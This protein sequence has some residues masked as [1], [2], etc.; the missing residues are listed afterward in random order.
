[1]NHSVI[2]TIRRALAFLLA[3][4]VLS[5]SAGCSR[6]KGTVPAAAV[7]TLTGAITERTA[8]VR[9]HSL[10]AVDPRAMQTPMAS[11]GL[12]QLFLDKKSYGIAL[13]EKTR[14]KYWYAMPS[15]TGGAF[16]DGACVVTLD[17]LYGN[18]VY[19]L[20]SQDD[21]VQYGNVAVLQEDASKDSEFTVC[22]VLTADE[23]TAG[24]ITKEEIVGGKIRSDR[25]GRT[26]IAYAVHVTYTLRDGNLYVGAQWQ[27]LSEN[28]DATVRS[29]S[30]LP[31]FGAQG[32]AEKG[33][34]FLIPDGCGAAIHTDIQDPAFENIDLKVYGADPAVGEDEGTLPALC[35]AFASKQGDN[36]FA[37]IIEAGDAVATIQARRGAGNGAL[38]R[39][40]ASFCITD[41]HA[42]QKNGKDVTFVSKTSYTGD[43]RLCVRLLGGGNAGLDGITAAC[44]EQFMRMGYLSTDTIRNEEYLP[45]RLEIRGAGDSSGFFRTANVMTSFEQAQ[46]MLT[47]MKAKGINNVDIRYMGALSGGADQQRI[48]A[49]RF[50]RGLGG[51]NGLNTLSEFCTAQGHSL[52]LDASLFTYS[53]DNRFGAPAALSIESTD[54]HTQQ[55]LSDGTKQRALLRLNL[56]EEMVI[57]LLT[58]AKKV[59]AD[60]F[61]LADAGNV[62]YS[63]Y[64]EPYTNRAAAADILRTQLPA[65]S[66]DRLLMIDGGNFYAIRYADLLNRLPQSPAKEER[67]KLYTA[68]PFIQM[69]LHGTL[70]YA[71][72]PVNLAED[73]VA[74]QLRS[75]E[76]GACPC[77][78]WCFEKGDETLYYENQLNDA[79]A[80]YQKAN[81]ALADLRDAR[82]MDN[83]ETGTSGIH[84][85]QYDNGAIVYV[86][87]NDTAS[88]VG[89]IRVSAHAFQRIG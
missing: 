52:F 13:Y 8:Q 80:F 47:R 54:A 45:F 59:Q 81:A 44:R 70:D 23:T 75:V 51:R 78:A 89:N 72:I 3:L 65:M 64:T 32:K 9:D 12:V 56:L 17:V 39:V 88:T 1:M 69:I 42:G 31:W 5:A 40:G 15:V 34:Y 19:R 20:N 30:L 46:D 49:I 66:T 50:G 55:V 62:L 86:N 14:E 7:R 6:G 43:V 22:Y 67:D 27:N 53:A 35:P 57:G 84:F 29:L 38:T 82:I 25:F 68:V 37:V 71:G 26:D 41:M 4:A 61:C 73:P 63:D 11:S 74:A 48:G 33:D 36:A 18:T 87:Y 21:S 24:K 85:T 79:V 76:F 60:G 28:P 58:D 16:D 77:Y 2:K 83:G 10:H